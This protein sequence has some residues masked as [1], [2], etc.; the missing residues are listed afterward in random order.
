M[1]FSFAGMANEIEEKP[2]ETIK[3]EKSAVVKAHCI[4]L[5]YAVLGMA[6]DQGMDDLDAMELAQDVRQACENSL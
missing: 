3:V 5:A 6:A 4:A 1:A 2:I